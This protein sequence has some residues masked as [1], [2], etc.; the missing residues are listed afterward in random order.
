METLE[1]KNHQAID[2]LLNIMS[3]LRLKCPWDKKQT[4]ESLRCN[5]IEEVYELAD[6]VMDGNMDEIRKEL[7]DIL[8]HVVF[9][10]K[11]GEE[12]NKFDFADVANG[13]CEKLII[14]HPHVFG[15]AKA[16][17]DEAVKVNWEKIKLNSKEGRKSVLEGVPNSLPA[18]IKAY[19]I[20][21]KVHGVNFDWQNPQDVLNK[22]K[23]EI[24]EFEH[25][26][27]EHDHEKMENELGDVL[28]SII[29]Y[30]RFM[31]INPENA[32][33]KTNR[34]FINRFQRME[35]AI[36]DDHKNITDMQLEEMDIYWNKI[37]EDEK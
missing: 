36:A 6:A 8:L 21:D 27:Q 35:Q 14:R 9:Y 3:E 17:T 29:N 16:D 25:E 4:L 15:D 12:Q 5:T 7:G 34:K 30:A 23:E 2:R 19:R 13:L 33:E 37:K 1:N 18:M 26:Q 20:Q 28:F 11:I 22:V 10:C 24:A 31:H 32:L